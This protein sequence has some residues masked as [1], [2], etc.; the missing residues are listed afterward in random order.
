MYDCISIGSATQDVFV[1]SDCA[2]IHRLQTID[3]EQAYIAFEYG[4]KVLV[5]QLF[6]SPGGGAV[7]VGI[8]LSRLGLRTAVVTEVGEDDSA[9][10]VISTLSECGVDTSMIARNQS[11]HTGYSVILTGFDG[12][13]TVLVHRGAA[14]DLSHED[15]DWAK[16]RQT[17]WIFLGA[18]VGPS[19]A[20]W[21]E[22]AAFAQ[23]HNLNL[24][25]NPGGEQ[26]KQG[27]DNLRCVFQATTAIFL[28]Q[29]EA[30]HLTGVEEKRGEEDER[31]A[32][33]RLHDAGCKLVVMTMGKKGAQAYDGV[34]RYVVPAKDVPVVSNLGAGDAFGSGCVAA[35]HRG[36]DVRAALIAGSRNAE[37]VLGHMGATTGLLTW[38]QVEAALKA[39]G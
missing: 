6:V 21:N 28:N 3:A 35:L 8:A 1:K 14:R 39:E 37:A 30:Y 33:Q 5:D 29:D 17:K 10:M 15:I 34:G 22:V 13:R 25:I 18:M 31:E 4:A 16:F 36:L 19:A 20:L 27:F 38:E 2:A 26:I 7:N 23:V 24:A 12:D 9:N 11:I 32:L